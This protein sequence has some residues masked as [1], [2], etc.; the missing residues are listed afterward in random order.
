[1]HD[2]NGNLQSD[3]STTYGYDVENR[4]ISASG[5]GNATLAY[6]PAGRLF[7]VQ[8]TAGATTRL[9][10]D[11]DQL[12]AEYD[13]TGTLLR[14]YV[15]GSGVDEPLLWYEGSG[16]GNRRHLRTDHQGSVIAVTDAA[17]NVVGVNSYDEFGV[18]AGTNLG[19]FQ[20]TGQA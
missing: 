16:L 17:G 15:H 7:Q 14:R 11:G 1:M 13:G 4:L 19:R 2:D 8:V 5:S 20:Y 10:Y 6:D 9:L 3:G 12:V 18:G